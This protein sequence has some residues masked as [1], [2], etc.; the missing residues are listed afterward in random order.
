[1]DKFGYIRGKRGPPGPK[2]KDAIPL[3]SWCPDAMLMM[4]RQSEA[5]T[6][7]FND[8]DSGV[9]HNKKTGQNALK[10]QFGNNHALC[11]KNFQNP[12]KVGRF[13][14]LPLKNTLYQIRDIETATANSTMCLIAFAFKTTTELSEE[15]TIFT[16]KS[17]TRG[18]TISKSS[19]NFLG[20]D[21]L[22][23]EYEYRDW[24]TMMIQYSNTENNDG[25]CFFVL[26]ERKGF[27]MPHK[28]DVRDD[29]VYIGGNSKGEKSANVML[30]NFELYWKPFDQEQQLE[31][32]DYLV[33]QV[34]VD[35]VCHDMDKRRLSQSAVNF[36]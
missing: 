14:G 23:L 24:N 30:L 13:Y 29:E 12:T 11:L 8:A 5:C 32:N 33:P 28:T 19:L 34:M 3:Y 21:P 2:G 26:N 36:K 16:N 27:F 35:L 17:E 9:M 22:S 4:F 10:D 31:P 18:V 15:V 6:Y 1:M 7:Y 25:Q 20:T